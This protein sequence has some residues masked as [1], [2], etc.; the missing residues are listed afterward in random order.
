MSLWIIDPSGRDVALASLLS[1]FPGN[2]CL[3]LHVHFGVYEGLKFCKLYARGKEINEMAKF[4]MYC[5]LKGAHLWP[6]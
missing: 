4:C 6:W 5:N 3:I 1:D 2:L